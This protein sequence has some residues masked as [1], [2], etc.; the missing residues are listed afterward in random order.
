VSAL[1]FSP[2]WREEIVATSSEGKLV[3]E[4]TMGKEH[5]YF[6]DEARWAAQA[7]A[8]ARGQWQ[9]YRDE[10]EKWCRAN[11][12]PFTLTGDAHMYEES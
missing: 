6:P 1:R 12:V 8:W 11:R 2:R 5:V 10:C 3:F 7:P 4:F 9:Q